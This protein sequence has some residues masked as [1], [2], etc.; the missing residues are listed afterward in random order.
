[1]SLGQFRFGYYTPL[2]AETVAFYR[3]RLGFPLLESWDRDMDDRG[4]LFSVASGVI[5][6]IARPTGPSTH[7]WDDRP[8]QGTFM[9]VEV[10]DVAAYSRQVAEKHVP[11]VQELT[12]Q[13]WGH[14]SFSVRE[15]SGLTLYFFEEIP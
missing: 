7:L 8:P 2:Y 14:R 1:M 11:F 3:E 15:P 9:V 6:V 13:P 12:D 10:A 5:E 4:S